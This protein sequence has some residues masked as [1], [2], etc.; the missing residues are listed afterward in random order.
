MTRLAQAGVAS[1]LS[2][3]PV[4]LFGVMLQVCDAHKRLRQLQL[5]ELLAD[6]NGTN[7]Q[8][9][10][11]KGKSTHQG[12]C[13]SGAL[14]LPADDKSG[15]FPST[16]EDSASVSRSGV[17]HIVKLQLL[18]PGSLLTSLQQHSKLRSAM[19]L[20]SATPQHRRSHPSMFSAASRTLSLPDSC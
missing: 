16:A 17:P 11:L 6:G 14:G 8:A 12:L 19:P 9:D 15:L 20:S 4:I 10:G 1:W 13:H 2:D 18:Q 3:M 7:K 5:A